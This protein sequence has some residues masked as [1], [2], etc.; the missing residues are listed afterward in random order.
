MGNDVAKSLNGVKLA[1]MGQMDLR[2][3]FLKDDPG[4]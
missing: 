3:I 1:E 4:C 2:S